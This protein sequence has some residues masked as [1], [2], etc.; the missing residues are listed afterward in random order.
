MLRRDYLEL[1]DHHVPVHLLT[2]HRAVIGTTGRGFR[3]QRW[4]FLVVVSNVPRRPHANRLYRGYFRDWT[5]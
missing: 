4:G 2:A 3:R 1:C 5:D